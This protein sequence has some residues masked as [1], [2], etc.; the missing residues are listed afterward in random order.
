MNAMPQAM[1]EVPCE[2]LCTLYDQDPAS[3][4]TG[5]RKLGRRRDRF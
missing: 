4:V 2:L 5:V 3:R 1:K